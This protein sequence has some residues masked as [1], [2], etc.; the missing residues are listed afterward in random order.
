MTI[1]HFTH[2]Y[3]VTNFNTFSRWLGQKMK[4]LT[5]YSDPNLKPNDKF[6]H[7]TRSSQFF[8]KNC[9]IGILFLR[10]VG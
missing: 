1:D 10:Y 5:L 9:Q 2:E 4:T 3:H 7:V 8:A 6:G